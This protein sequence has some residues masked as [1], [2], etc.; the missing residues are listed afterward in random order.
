[1]NLGTEEILDRTLGGE[2]LSTADVRDAGSRP[3][4]RILSRETF[5]TRST[6]R[7]SDAAA[8]PRPPTTRRSGIL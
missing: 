1:M 3:T 4:E 2:R 8:I 7:T 5:D 6:D